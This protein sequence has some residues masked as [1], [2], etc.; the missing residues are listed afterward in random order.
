MPNV[1]I[2]KCISCEDTD[3]E[4]ND[5]GFCECCYIEISYQDEREKQQKYADRLA[6]EKRQNA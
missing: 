2:N 4:L 6:E 5:E 3:V 1:Q